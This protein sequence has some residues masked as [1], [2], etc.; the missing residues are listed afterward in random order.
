M[1][2]DR[3]KVEWDASKLHASNS[4]S[5]GILH[6]DQM[7]LKILA[8]NVRLL[9]KMKLDCKFGICGRVFDHVTGQLALWTEFEEFLSQLVFAIGI[10]MAETVPLTLTDQTPCMCQSLFLLFGTWLLIARRRV[11]SKMKLPACQACCGQERV[12]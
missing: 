12:G 11:L 6:A 3:R 7:A 8:D 10:R 2:F 1:F 4:S 5:H 9:S